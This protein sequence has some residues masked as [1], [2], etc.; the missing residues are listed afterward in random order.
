MPSYPEDAWIHEQNVT[1]T[2]AQ[3]DDTS[4]AVDASFYLRQ[5]LD[6]PPTHEPLLPALGGLT[7]IETHI[8]AD[9]DSWKQNNTTPFF[10]FSGQPVQGEDDVSIQRG[11]TA[12]VKTDE[13]WNLYFRGEAHK[14]VATFGQD[15]RA[16]PISNLFPLLQRLLKK[17][18]LHFL[19]APFNASA[20][21]AY[22]DMIESDQCSAVLGS[23]ELLLYPI[24][25]HIIK[26]IDWE[27]G[28]VKMTSKK[29]LTQRLGCSESMFI[30]VLLM[31]GTSFLPPFPPLLDVNPMGLPSVNDA[32]NMLRTAEKSVANLCGSFN[33]VLKR[34][35]PDWLDQYH[36]ARMMIEHLIY[37]E[38]DGSLKVH[39]FDTLT[40]DN[41]KYLGKQLPPELLHYLNTG[42]ISAR[43]PGWLTHAR[44]TILPS[45]DGVVSDEYKKLVTS[46]LITVREQT[47][48]LVLPRLNRAISYVKFPVRVWYD[49]KFE[50]EIVPP[51]SA[52][53]PVLE[54][55]QKW[56]V[57]DATMKQFFPVA[58]HG[59]I[60][61]ELNALKNSDFVKTLLGKEKN[62]GIESAD[63]IVSL[64]VWRFLHLRGYIDDTHQL[65][66]WGK[67]LAASLDAIAP[68]I[69]ENPNDNLEDSVLLAFELLRYD[70]LNTRNKHAELN[71]LP[72]NGSEDDKASLLLVSRCALLLK[73][74]HEAN[75]YTGPLSKNFLHYHSLSSSIREANRDLLEGIVT[76]MLLEAEAKKERDDY[77]EISQQLPFLMDNDVGLGI[78]VKTWLDDVQ[79]SEPAEVRQKKMDEWT[80]KYVP[81]ATNFGKDLQISFAFFDA[82]H[83]GIK[84]LGDSQASIDQNVW[85]RA[86]EYLQPRR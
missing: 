31:T 8:E 71:G 22:F 24:K 76:S 27:A 64:A 47:L 83:V 26:T 82:L 63:S 13:A 55:A 70:L 57:K 7:G 67:A 74:H 20:Q 40:K 80:P 45:L 38:E 69:E 58:K 4:I 9:L 62:K 17:R 1:V 11:K 6:C 18:D 59:S 42:L 33:D 29:L 25:D 73:L 75:G 72:M 10:I 16:Y 81:F 49:D 53:N 86:A 43:L 3:L 56:N 35:I 78:A 5:F 65:T 79:L 51:R 52:T 61:F 12:I 14:A 36:K 50:Y 48:L 66:I 32:A 44:I 41:Y 19:V 34:T 30:D 28:I 84:T 77:L 85:A 23:Q 21:L 68:T 39:N 2:V 46:Q 54:Q 60:R 15:G 37:I